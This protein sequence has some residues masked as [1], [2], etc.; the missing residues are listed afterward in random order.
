M[1]QEAK[2][3]RLFAPGIAAEILF[4]VWVRA[5]RK[6]IAANSPALVEGWRG[7]GGARIDLKM[8]RFEDG[9]MRRFEDGKI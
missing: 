1:A 6:K 2:L 5:R 4:S 8:G 7:E 9:M 3:R